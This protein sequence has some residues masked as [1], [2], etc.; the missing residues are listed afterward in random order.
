MLT[1]LLELIIGLL[2]KANVGK[3]TFFNAATDS[4]I[5]IANFPFTTINPNIGVA[6]V[7]VNCVCK[8]FGVLD[9]PIT[10]KCI[11][12]IRYIPIKLIDVAGL[13]PGAHS[14]RG[15]G[16]KFLDDARQADVLV[17]VIDISGST[18][19]EGRPVNPGEGNPLFDLEFIEDEFDLW[20][21]SLILRDWD[22]IIRESE[23]LKQRIETVLSNRLSGL[24][25]SEQ[26]IR[27]SLDYINLIKK[28]SEWTEEDL[29]ILSKQIRTRSKP[30]ILAANKADISSSDINIEKLKNL[31]RSFFPTV[32][33][34][35]LLLRRASH[36][37][38]IYYLPG[39][40]SFK[41]KQSETLSNKQNEAL[42]VVSGIL[43]KFGSTGIQRVINHACFEILQNIVV[44]PVEDEYKF[45]DKKGNVFPDARIISNHS[46]AKDLAY[47]I[48]N[49][50][51]KGFLY[52]IDA[53]TK[54]RIG[55]EHK[56]KNDDI[57]KIV[58]TMS[59]N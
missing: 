54:Q 59:R 27:N 51:G 6:F 58:S 26:L 33:E 30:I 57:I 56:L 25:I 44:Y 37:N 38:L 48:H 19:E 43:L 2:G 3:S 52:A 22:K 7:R 39:D 34:A 14:G 47:L 35:E 29:L 5:P 55:A 50:L 16:N 15:L 20:I 8:E 1:N 9:N 24:S 40:S 23:N 53:R 17:H 45:T 4:S 10:S 13:V 42:E 11:G 32:C 18:D 49:D 31:K 41:I 36:K 46:T 12:G 21:R 28:P